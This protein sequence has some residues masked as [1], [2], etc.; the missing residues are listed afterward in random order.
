MYLLLLSPSPHLL[1][2][3]VSS[4]LAASHSRAATLAGER[5][6]LWGEVQA[7]TSE[8]GKAREV[9]A[10][11]R[12]EVGTLQTQLAEAQGALRDASLRM[13]QQV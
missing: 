7:L 1:L 12:D 3:T 10:Q 11:L 8:L 6:G 9:E 5:D 2:Q 13:T 4:E